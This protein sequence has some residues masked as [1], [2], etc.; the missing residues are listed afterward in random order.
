MSKPHGYRQSAAEAAFCFVVLC[1]PYYRSLLFDGLG[2]TI[3]ALLLACLLMFLVLRS[4]D[5]CRLIAACMVKFPSSWIAPVRHQDIRAIFFSSLAV[6]SAPS[7]SPLF[8]RPP[9]AFS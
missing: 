6:P 2:R 7:L 3:C 9:P 8:Q 1:L 5:V 4:G